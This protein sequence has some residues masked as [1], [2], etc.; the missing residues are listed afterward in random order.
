MMQRRKFRPNYL[1]TGILTVA[2]LFTITWETAARHVSAS[3]FYTLLTA[4][5]DTTKVP[6]NIDTSIKKNNPVDTIPSKDS[7]IVKQKTDTFS[8]KLSK[9]SLDAPVKYQAKDW[10][11]C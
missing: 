4:N 5:I 7:F 3:N 9:D 1:F 2:M 10:P 8:L 11:W 6:T